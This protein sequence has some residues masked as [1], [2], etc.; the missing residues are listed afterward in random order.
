M[1]ATLKQK[2]LLGVYVFI[3]LSIPIGA[4]LASQRQ[5]TQ[6]SAKEQK[7]TKGVVSTSPK[8]A[9]PSAKQL[10]GS[11]QA[12]AKDSSPSPD[13][14][15]LPQIATSFGPTLS[16]KTILE[17]RPVNNQAAKMFVGIIDGDLTNSPKFLLSFTVDLPASGQYSN[18]SLA[19]LNPGSRYTAILKAPAQ[20]ATSSAFTMSPTVSHL[21]DDNTLNLISGDLNEDNVINSADYSITRK[22]AGLT[23][24]S[25]DWNE[26]ADL[27][28]DGLINTFDLAIIAKNI[29]QVGA[30]GAWT[31]SVPK[32]AST[33]ATLNT[34][35]VGGPSDAGSGYWV[36]VPR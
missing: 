21:N 30:S 9:T 3:L 29:G 19:G 35:P 33:S 18:L 17:G 16:F 20:I 15:S 13:S 25:S 22:G 24:D 27:N 31:S 32:V 12:A 10:L 23:P 6:S 36:W 5:T 28:K 1:F 14:S 7:A 26:N 8:S 2:L 4:Y 11:S 34:L